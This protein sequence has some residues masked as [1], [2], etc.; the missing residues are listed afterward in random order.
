MSESPTSAKTRQ[1]RTSGSPPTD[2][3]RRRANS[4]PPTRRTAIRAGAPTASAYLFESNR[5]RRVQLWVI[6]LAGGEAQQLTTI[7]T[8]AATGTLVARRQADRLRLGRLSRVLRPSRSP[9]ATSSTRKRSR[10]TSKN[11]VKAKVFT[12]LF[13]RHW[14]CYVEDKRQHLFVVGFD[15]DGA[16]IEAT[17]SP[18]DV[19][20]GDRDAYPTS[21]TFCVGDDF[22]F[23]PD[24]KYLS[25]PPCRRRTRRG[26]RITTSA[27]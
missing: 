16:S 23:S 27:A 18:R 15:A 26:A 12:R 14:D 3:S 24:G 13:F 7:S 2:G 25:S 8:E 11:P 17:G 5:S 1:R 20:P 22:T 21:T 19:T 6:D 10:Q 9:R 4:R